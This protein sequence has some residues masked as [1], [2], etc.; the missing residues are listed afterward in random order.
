MRLMK[1]EFLMYKTQV[2]EVQIYHAKSGDQSD[3]LKISL[4]FCDF[5][6]YITGFIPN[7]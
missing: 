1:P 3:L 5:H 6:H 4:L 7:T 2:Y